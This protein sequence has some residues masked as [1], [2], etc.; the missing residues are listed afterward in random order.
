M[1]REVQKLGIKVFQKVDKL[2]IRE[3]VVIVIGDGSYK[4]IL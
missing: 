2:D 4:I 3:G 1:G